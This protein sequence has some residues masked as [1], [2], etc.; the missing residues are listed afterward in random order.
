MKNSLTITMVL[1]FTVSI[2]PRSVKSWD[3]TN[4]ATPKAEAKQPKT[5]VLNQ[6][7]TYRLVVEKVDPGVALALMKRWQFG[8]EFPRELLEAIRKNPKL[9]KSKQI[10]LLNSRGKPEADSGY[11]RWPPEGNNLREPAGGLLWYVNGEKRRELVVSIDFV[12]DQSVGKDQPNLEHRFNELRVTTNLEDAK[13]AQVHWNETALPKPSGKLAIEVD[14]FVQVS[15]TGT[16]AERSSES[17]RLA[18]ELL[19]GEIIQQLGRLSA[20]EMSNA[21]H[22]GI[23]LGW[24]DQDHLR[25]G[26]AFSRRGNEDPLGFR[27]SVS[28]RAFPLVLMRRQLQDDGW[29]LVLRGHEYLGETE[30]NISV[31]RPVTFSLSRKRSNPPKE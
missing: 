22:H 18:D 13:I 17:I 11:I 9:E 20:A 24:M 3:D 31:F 4:Q 26:L 15:V 27:Y 12:F 21:S 23:S 10:V 30:D 1:F 16:L 29:P 6:G 19:S 2:G 7:R 14:D 25:H 5:T 8:E 28:G